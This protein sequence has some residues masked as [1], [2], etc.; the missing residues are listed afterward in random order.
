MDLT[1]AFL[2]L[3]HYL[4]TLSCCFVFALVDFAKKPG[5]DSVATTQVL[6]KWVNY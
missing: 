1:S 2:T 3:V 4:I 6:S 5:I